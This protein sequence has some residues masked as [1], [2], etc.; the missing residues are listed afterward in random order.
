MRNAV[1]SVPHVRRR[2]G[3]LAS[4]QKRLTVPQSLLAQ[5]DEIE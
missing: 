4:R 2:G 1:Y 3:D 5:P